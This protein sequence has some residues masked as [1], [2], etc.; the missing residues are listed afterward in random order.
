MDTARFWIAYVVVA[1][2]PAVFVYWLSMHGGIV[3]WRRVN[4]SLALAVHLAFVATVG[5]IVYFA[6]DVFLALEFGANPVLIVVSA[7]LLIV[8]VLLR[9]AIAR[10]IPLR[11]LVGSTELEQRANP[12]EL[13]TTGIY[14]RIRH[15]RYVQLIVVV[16]AFSLFSNYAAAYVAFALSVP[17]VFVIAKLE[18]RELRARFGD[19]YREY[20]SRVP[21]FVP[22]SGL[23]SGPPI[24]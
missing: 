8:S 7:L 4:R 17:A 19:A 20:A 23:R 10:E 12:S 16:L 1:A 14:S 3:F 18:E 2:V 9:R 21:R 22:R 5:A 6:R 15:P 24:G 13:V 11:T